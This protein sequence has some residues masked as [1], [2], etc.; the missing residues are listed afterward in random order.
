MLNLVSGKVAIN[1]NVFIFLMEATTTSQMNNN[2]IIT[3]NKS[4]TNGNTKIFKQ[5]SN[6]VIHITSL[7]RLAKALYLASIDDLEI[8]FCFL[9]I[10]LL[11]LR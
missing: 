9:V 8:V 11:V 7:I 3:K 4:W 1:F 6:L 5:S 10:D 2:L